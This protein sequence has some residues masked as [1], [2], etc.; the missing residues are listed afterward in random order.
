L[1]Q[2]IL[3]PETLPQ[4]ANPKKHTIRKIAFSECGDKIAALNMDGTL[5]MMNFDLRD[6]SKQQSIYD[7]LAM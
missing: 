2:W 3:D 1:N 4:N 7:T 5:F 6:E